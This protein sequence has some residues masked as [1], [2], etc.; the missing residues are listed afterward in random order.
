MGS[1]T[2]CSPVI[3]DTVQS[4][5]FPIMSLTVIM[6]SFAFVK[7]KNVENTVKKSTINILISEKTFAHLKGFITI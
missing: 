2:L 1:A 7:K 3:S 4:Q 6:T 5:L